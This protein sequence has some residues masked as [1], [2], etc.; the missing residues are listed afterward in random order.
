[1]GKFTPI[2]MKCNKEQ[3]KAV[4]PKLKGFEIFCIGEFSTCT[5][6]CLFDDGSITNGTI[7]IREGKIIHETWN[8]KVFLEACGVEVEKP[9]KTTLFLKQESGENYIIVNDVKYIPEPEFQITKEQ[10]LEIFDFTCSHGKD[11]L[12]E[13]F[14]QAFDS[15]NVELEIGK[16][17]KITDTTSQFRKYECALVFNTGNDYNYGFGYTRKEWTENFMN[18]QKIINRGTDKVELATHQEIEEALTKECVR[19]GYK[20]GD[21]VEKIYDASSEIICGNDACCVLGSNN[22][23]WYGGVVVFNNGKFAKVIPTKTRQEAEKE[24]N[25]SR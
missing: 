17:Y 10:I 19:L 8:E 3:F 16:W 14:P 15:D 11:K 2:Y 25:C 18:I 22:V 24:L 21:Y 13:S 5:Y 20:V 9:S 7:S 12:K 1:M 23:L 6:L 4:E